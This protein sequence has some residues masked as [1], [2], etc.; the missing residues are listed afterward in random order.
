MLNTDDE[1]YGSKD[2]YYNRFREQF[3]EW[4]KKTDA[5]SH[6]GEGIYIPI[7]NLKAEN[8]SH[9]PREDN[10]LFHCALACTILIDQVMYT[11]FKTDY[12]KFQQMTLYPKIEYGISN[13]NVRPWD[14]THSGIGLT[15]LERFIAFFVQDLKNFFNENK[16]ETAT[17]DAVKT[18]ILNDK[19]IMDGSR[20]EILRKNLKIMGAS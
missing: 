2:Y 1:K 3:N 10:M 8:L 4:A 6:P 7:Q 5:H 19:D 9:I 20:G 14:I 17:W 12:K 11:Y 15:T 18:A 16:F 13:M